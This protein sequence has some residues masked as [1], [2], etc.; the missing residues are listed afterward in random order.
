MRTRP[1]PLAALLLPLAPVPP[2]HGEDVPAGA[3]NEPSKL[4]TQDASPLG[5]G[6]WQVQT[7]L[8]HVR[9][10][11]AWD[12]DG[13]PA[14]RPLSRAT[15]L[16]T[17]LNHGVT[18]ELDLGLG[19]GYTWL[20]DDDADPDDGHGVTDLV[21]VAK[22]RLLETDGGS[23]IGVTPTLL[24]PIGDEGSPYCLGPGQGY[25]AFDA[26]AALVQDWAPSW[27]TN[28][29]VGYVAVFGDREEDRGLFSANTAVG[30]QPLPW[31]QPEAELHYA[32]AFVRHASCSD[33]AAVTAAVVLPLADWICPRAG[34]QQVFAGRETDHATVVKVSVDWNF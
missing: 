18:D 23:S 34:V 32:R 25:W 9:A 11:R 14:A 17:V 5:A 4:F 22:W 8:V 16:E 28:I 30:W 24:I 27:S 3:P 33:H 6:G 10:S 15:L 31:L 20:L 29:D 13:G 2:T 12:A 19:L 1:L 21:A 26:R 7:N